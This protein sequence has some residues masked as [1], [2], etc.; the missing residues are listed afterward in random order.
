MVDTAVVDAAGHRT[1]GIGLRKFG[2]F[3]VGGRGKGVVGSSF[4]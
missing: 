2:T 4:V 1:I 3:S